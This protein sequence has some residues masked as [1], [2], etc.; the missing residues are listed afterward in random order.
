MS[1]YDA[2]IMRAIRAVWPG[3]EITITRGTAMTDANEAELAAMKMASE[4]GGEMIESLGQTDMALWTVD[5]WHGFIEA[6]CGGYVESLMAQQAEV[7][8][9]LAKI[10]T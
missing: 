2:P 1:L 10:S 7:A 8:A 6:V 5:Q 3:A 4:R 9:A